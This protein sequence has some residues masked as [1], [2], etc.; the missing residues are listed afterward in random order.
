MTPFFRLAEQL[1]QQLQIGDDI[2]KFD[3]VV[4]LIGHCCAGLV[5]DRSEISQEGE[6]VGR[7]SLCVSVQRDERLDQGMPVARDMEM[8]GLGND[9]TPGFER[10]PAI[11]M[12]ANGVGCVEQHAGAGFFHQA[13]EEGGRLLPRP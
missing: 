9:V 13:L 2:V 1:S 10:R 6:R 12:G 5:E 8:P 7:Q 4:A 3:P 11:A